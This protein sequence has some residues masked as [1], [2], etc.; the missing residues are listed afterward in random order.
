VGAKA[1][2]VGACV[3][4]VLRALVYHFKR[5]GRKLGAQALRDVFGAQVWC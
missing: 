2:F 1:A 3:A 5:Q 4:L